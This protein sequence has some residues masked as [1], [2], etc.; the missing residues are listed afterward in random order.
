MKKV[1]VT[2]LATGF[3]LACN[4]VSDHSENTPSKQPGEKHQEHGKKSEALVLNNGVKWK[5]DSTTILNVAILQNIVTNA[6]KESLE[7]YHQAAGQLEDG[8]N[9]MVKE[10]KMK[11]ADHDA[12]HKWLEPLMV[13]TKELKKEAIVENAATLLSEIEKQVAL[14]PQYFE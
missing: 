8:L 6:K 5:A 12:L 7:N 4:P 3:L 11:G 14:F 2:L 9:K 1:A 13:K 10:C